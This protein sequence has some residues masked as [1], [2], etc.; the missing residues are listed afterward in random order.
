MLER[1]VTFVSER[2]ETLR[3]RPLRRAGRRVGLR[4]RVSVSEAR[5]AH[6]RSVAAGDGAC[7]GRDFSTRR[8]ETVLL[9]RNGVGS[10]R[11]PGAPMWRNQVSS[12]RT[13]MEQGAGKTP[14]LLDTPRCTVAGCAIAH[15]G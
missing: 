5:S 1:C 4:G 9:D 8:N 15:G 13:R 14:R 10:G 6:A 2:L 7:T 3:T 12:L 11:G